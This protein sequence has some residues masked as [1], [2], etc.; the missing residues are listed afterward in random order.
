MA[1]REWCAIFLSAAVGNLDQGK[2]NSRRAAGVGDRFEVRSDPGAVSQ[3]LMIKTDG[4][5]LFPLQISNHPRKQ[6]MD[7]RR[8]EQVVIVWNLFPG[9]DEAELPGEDCKSGTLS[10]ALPIHGADSRRQIPPDRGQQSPL[11]PLYR[12]TVGAKQNSLLCMR[13]H[14]SWISSF[15][16]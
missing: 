3:R 9:A 4:P 7:F 14:H 1:R 10:F 2:A 16:K 6:G 15:R 5:V 13:L 12:R 11:L 8:F